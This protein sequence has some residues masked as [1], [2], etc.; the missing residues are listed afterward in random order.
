MTRLNGGRNLVRS[1]GTLLIGAAI[2]LDLTGTI[3]AAN[4][5]T[6]AATGVAT[7]SAIDTANLKTAYLQAATEFRGLSGP[8]AGDGK[9]PRL[10]DPAAGKLIRLMSDQ[11]RFLDSV[12]YNT[13]N[14]ADLMSVCSAGNQVTMSYVLFDVQKNL[15]PDDAGASPDERNNKVRSLIRDNV[16]AFHPELTLLQPFLLQCAAVQIPILNQIVDNQTPAQLTNMRRAGFTRTRSQLFTTYY[17]FL[18]LMQ[19]E[20][21]GDTY[22]KALLGMLANTSGAFASAIRPLDRRLIGVELD[23]LGQSLKAPLADHLKRIRVAVS[24]PTC[25]GLCRY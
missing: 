3:R 20:Q 17:G 1:L 16:L 2:L 11:A 15:G 23:L 6:K 19:H 4:A 12:K 18:Q 24:K 9:M 10:E 5:E 8:Q 22:R 25:I 13:E 7:D 21:A 14:L